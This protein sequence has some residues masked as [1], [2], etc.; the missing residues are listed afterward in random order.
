MFQYA[1]AVNLARISGRDVYIDISFLC[2]RNRDSTFVMRDYQLDLFNISDPL[3]FL[4][5]GRS[6]VIHDDQFSFNDNV[7]INR[8]DLTSILEE[9]AS[10]NIDVTLTGFWQSTNTIG[11]RKAVIDLFTTRPNLSEESLIL[12]AKIHDSDSVMVNVR[13]ADFLDNNVNGVVGL[14][15]YARAFEHVRFVRPNAKFYIFSDDI[16]WCRRHFVGDNDHVVGHEHA[17]DRF[18]SYLYL[19]KACKHFVIPNS[20]FAWWAAYLGFA[21]DSIVIRPRLFMPGIGQEHGEIFD[22]LDWTIIE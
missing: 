16:D 1:T 11:N 14:E 13:R 4:P 9:I 12:L 17:G 8:I 10:S 3:V 15:Y 2:D 20:T 7:T 22:N 5:K 6:K 18:S 19:M 21:R